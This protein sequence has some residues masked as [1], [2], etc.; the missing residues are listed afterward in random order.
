VLPN[1]APAGASDLAEQF[2]NAVRNLKIAHSGS[3]TGV[4]TVSVGVTSHIPGKDF[5]RAKELVRSA[6]QALYAA[7]A[8]GRDRIHFDQTTPGWTSVFKLSEAS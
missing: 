6:D 3:P 7:K 4:V 1:T 5:K 8:A 2:R